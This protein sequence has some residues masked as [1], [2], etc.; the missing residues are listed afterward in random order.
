MGLPV[1]APHCARVRGPRGTGR[2]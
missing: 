1:V 2:V